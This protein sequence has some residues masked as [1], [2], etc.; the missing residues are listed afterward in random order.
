MRDAVGTITVQDQRIVAIAFELQGALEAASVEQNIVPFAE[1]L[2]S[3]IGRPV[4][5]AGAARATRATHASHFLPCYNL[6]R[7]PFS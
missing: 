7:R 5:A 2:A 3:Q 1:F 6:H 4:P